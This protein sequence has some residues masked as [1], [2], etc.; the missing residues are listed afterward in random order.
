MYLEIP[1]EGFQQYPGSQMNFATMQFSNLPVCSIPILHGH[2]ALVETSC[3][4][5]L[6]PSEYYVHLLQKKR[7]KLCIC[8]HV[9]IQSV[10]L[11]YTFFWGQ[12]ILKHKTLA[13]ISFIPVANCAKPIFG[14]LAIHIFSSL[15]RHMAIQCTILCI[16][17]A[18]DLRRCSKN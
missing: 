9:N 14:V 12:C 5:C 11:E 4:I 16:T 10:E 17:W 8:K 2:E 13:G 18:L 1:Q 15:C 3:W 6:L 7:K